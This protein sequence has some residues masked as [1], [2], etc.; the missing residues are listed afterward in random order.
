[1]KETEGERGMEREKREGG[2]GGRERQRQRQR[3]KD[4]VP[5]PTGNLALEAF[6]FTSSEFTRVH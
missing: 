5:R 6:S 2:E 1:M 3:Q 4:C